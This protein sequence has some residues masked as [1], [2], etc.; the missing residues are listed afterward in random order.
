[1]NA[2]PCP[3]CGVSRNGLEESCPSCGW[4]PNSQH[5]LVQPQIES[6]SIQP[7]SRPSAVF[8]G[9][10]TVL[11]ILIANAFPVIIFFE[12]TNPLESKFDSLLIALGVVQVS[13]VFVLLLSYAVHLFRFKA[14][15]EN[16]RPLWLA[17][18][19]IGNLLVFPIYWFFY[20]WRA[21]GRTS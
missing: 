17:M 5:S 13:L 16:Q 4:A 7:L 9:A 11:P 1:M 10:I 21:S 15:P 3:K 18:M 20:V 6:E 14:V 8:F 2:F 19:V 12:F